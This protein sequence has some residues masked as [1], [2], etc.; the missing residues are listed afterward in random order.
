[1]H[2][3]VLAVVLGLSSASAIA[4][5]LSQP[6]STAQGPKFAMYEVTVTNLTAAIGFT[7][8]LIATHGSS[9]ELFEAGEPASPELAMLAED[10]LTRPLESLLLSM[11]GTLATATSAGPTGPGQSTTVLVKTDSPFSHLSL[12][13]MLVPTNDSFIALNAVQGPKQNET[14]VLY[15][16]AWDAGSEPNDELCASLPSGASFT[17]CGGPGG[18]GMPPGGEGFVHI[19]RGITGVGDLDAAERDWKNP[20]ARITVRRVIAN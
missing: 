1:M 10:G 14:L 3:N 13:S 6:A 8:I 2:R 18:G 20:V 5:V 11:P 17:E 9:V 4:L 7:P 12:A 19:S 15:V 16:P